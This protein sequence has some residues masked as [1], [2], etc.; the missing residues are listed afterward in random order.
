MCAML[1]ANDEK[2]EGVVPTF[3]QTAST[4]AGVHIILKTFKRNN[5]KKL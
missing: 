3:I 4:K 1:L 2:R 5:G